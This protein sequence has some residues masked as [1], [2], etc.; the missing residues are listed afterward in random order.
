MDEDEAYTTRRTPASR[1]ASRRFSVPVTLFSFAP[2]GSSTE[3]GTERMAAWWKITSTP[4]AA[5]AV[6]RKSRRSPSTTS[7]RE[8]ADAKARCSRLP[9]EKLSRT[10]TRWPS[11]RS[12]STTWEPMNPAPPVTRNMQGIIGG[13]RT[14]CQRDKA[15]KERYNEG[16]KRRTHHETV[17]DRRF[18]ARGGNAPH[19]PRPRP[20]ADGPPAGAAPG[21]AADNGAGHD[22][23]RPDGPRDGH[24][25]PGH[26]DVPD[27]A[28]DDASHDAPPDDGWSDGPGRHDGDDGRTDGPQD[29]GTHAPDARRDAEGQ[30][31]HPAQVRQ[32]ARR[33]QVTAEQRCSRGAVVH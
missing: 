4:R 22:G 9:E 19:L 24:D 18:S 32:D 15:M 8:S 27:Y 14:P 20:T 30:G 28:G 2:S 3:R 29:P 23:R 16:T 13:G 7:S 33:G 17:D 12:R 31:R 10:R 6:A 21:P 26:D 5:S 11:R 25:G 1:A